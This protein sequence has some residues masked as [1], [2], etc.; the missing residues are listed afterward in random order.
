M[1][2]VDIRKGEKK[3]EEDEGASVSKRKDKLS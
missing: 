3:T 1:I 2:N